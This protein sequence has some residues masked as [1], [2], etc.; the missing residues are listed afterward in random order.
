MKFIDLY[1]TESISSAALVTIIEDTMLCMNIK[2]EHC[3]D[4]AS[5][6]TGIKNGVIASGESQA[7]FSHCYGY[8]LNLGVGDTI[9]RASL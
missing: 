6:M 4:G 3:Y 8:A 1:L 7:I 9:K 5:A 2:L